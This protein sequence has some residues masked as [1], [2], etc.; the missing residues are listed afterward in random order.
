[1][2]LKIRDK[3]TGV[4]YSSN[5]SDHNKHAIISM[6][7]CTSY[8]QVKVQDVIDVSGKKKFSTKDIILPPI[9]SSP[10]WIDEIAIKDDNEAE[11][12]N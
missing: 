4:I 9:G 11:W 6:D 1:M 7:F 3:K 8:T 12:V 5:M 2:E 10:N